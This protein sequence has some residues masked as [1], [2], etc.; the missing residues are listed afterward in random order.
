MWQSYSK[1]SCVLRW[2]FEHLNGTTTFRD[3]LSNELTTALNALE[4]S[5]S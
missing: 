4:S 3:R 1:N 5:L 2:F